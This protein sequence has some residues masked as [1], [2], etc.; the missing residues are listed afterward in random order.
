MKRLKEKN[1]PTKI[2]KEAYNKAN[3]LSQ[4][5]CIQPKKEKHPNSEGTMDFKHD[6]I[7]TFN[8]NQ[9]YIKGVLDKH[10]HILETDQDPI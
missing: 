3:K 8:Q 7:T 6:F 10:W 4:E 9:R 1:D 5:I 2:V